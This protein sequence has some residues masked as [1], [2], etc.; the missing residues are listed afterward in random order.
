MHQNVGRTWS[1]RAAC[2]AGQ[3]I[4]LQGCQGQWHAIAS[5]NMTIDIDFEITD[6][7]S[8]GRYFVDSPDSRSDPCH[9]FFRLERLDNV[10]VSTGFESDDDV[11]GVALGSEHHNRSSGLRA[12]RTTDIDAVSAREHEV[13]KYYVGLA[14]AEHFQGLGAIRAEDRLEALPAQDDSEH[15]SKCGVVIDHE[16]SATHGSRSRHRHVPM[17]S[18]QG[19]PGA[20]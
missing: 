19:L 1:P 13:E 8:L 6:G 5:H 17:V 18:P 9:E 16:H 3:E 14:L 15:L 12:D 2:Q 7:E 11:Y 4:E 10:V 20:N